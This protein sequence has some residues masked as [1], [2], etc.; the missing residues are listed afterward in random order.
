MDMT[1][2]F[3]IVRTFEDYEKLRLY[4]CLWDYFPEAPASWPEHVEMRAAHAGSLNREYHK[5]LDKGV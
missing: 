5:W 3:T 2:Y 1:S 4:G